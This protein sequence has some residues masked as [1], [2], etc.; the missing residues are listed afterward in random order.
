MDKIFVNVGDHVKYVYVVTNTGNTV[1]TDVKIFDNKA[2]VNGGPISSL[3]PG[4][5]NSTAFTGLYAI[6]LQDIADAI[7]YNLATVEGKN[8]LN[9]KV[10][11]T[12]TDPTPCTSCAIKPDCLTCTMTPLVQSPKIT[13]LVSAEI[14]N[15]NDN[16]Q[17]QVGDKILYTFNI[18]NSGNTMLSNIRLED[19]ITGKIDLPYTAPLQMK[20]NMIFS[21]AYSLTKEDITV[22]K[23]VKQARA[24][25]TSPK[26]VEVTDLSDATVLVLSGCDVR[27]YNAV[28]P[29][30]DGNNDFLFIEGLECYTE[31]TVEI[32]D[33]WGVK[34]FGVDGYNNTSKAFRGMSEGRVTVNQSKGLPTGTYFYVVKYKNA[35]GNGNST[36]G[37]LQLI[38]D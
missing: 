19:V 37:Y 11:N 5:S 6:T 12:S 13:L 35:D 1:L 23:V 10:S 4:Q 24:F 30:G 38:N 14:M 21:V 28:S 26:G 29:D 22:G 33:R 9:L 36:S 15:K 7:V 3:A 25:G 27:V 16:G 2:I 32:F 31:N 34:V 8:P 18:T 17:V 20:E